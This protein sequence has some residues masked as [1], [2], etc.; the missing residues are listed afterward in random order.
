MSG[1]SSERVERE[2]EAEAVRRYGH[3]VTYI[4]AIEFHLLKAQ[5]RLERQ[6]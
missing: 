4:E 2:I 5:I 6:S 1:H 3:P